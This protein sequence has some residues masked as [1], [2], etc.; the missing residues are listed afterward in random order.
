MEVDTSTAATVAEVQNTN[1]FTAASTAYVDVTLS[2]GVVVAAA[3]GGG[4]LE[5]NAQNLGEAD[6]VDVVFVAD[7]GT[8]N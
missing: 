7:A 8:A 4:L 3:A 6:G 2:S 5:I 1:G